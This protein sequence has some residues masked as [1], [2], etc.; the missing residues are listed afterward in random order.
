[1][2][3][4]EL[5]DALNKALNETDLDQIAVWALSKYLQGAWKDRLG[6]NIRPF[7]LGQA[8]SDFFVDL[9]QHRLP[10]RITKQTPETESLLM[11]FFGAALGDK[12]LFWTQCIQIWSVTLEPNPVLAKEVKKYFDLLLQSSQEGKRLSSAPVSVKPPA[13]AP[14]PVIAQPQ[15]GPEPADVAAPAENEVMD[16]TQGT[17]APS[18]STVSFEPDETPT[19][20]LVPDSTGNGFK[21]EPPPFAPDSQAE[22]NPKTL[23][24]NA[25][26]IL[27]GTRVIPLNQPF[28]KIGRQL[29]NHIILEDPRVSRA[30]AHI[31]LVND[32]FVIFDLHSTGGT[33][34]NGRQTTQSV[35]YPGDVV[36]LA[37]VIFIYSQ[38]LPAKPGDVKIIELGSPFAA[39][40]PTAI[41]HKE[42]A[43]QKI[44][45]GD[46][47]LP[48]L[49]KTGPLQ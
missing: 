18:L 21:P 31:K 28:I 30:H 13:E 37:G 45:T 10:D 42:E 4:Q 44:K 23:P 34:V 15:D 12:S 2:T 40:R 14:T 46:K 8:M 3:A 48:D 25:Y 16:E 24:R 36:S 17:P 5:L 47:S 49:P 1:L 35:L 20:E 22:S 19:Q 33:F 11:D 27:Q 6:K 32:R 9:S 38:E 41:L 7:D 39:D 29:D 43:K 26:L